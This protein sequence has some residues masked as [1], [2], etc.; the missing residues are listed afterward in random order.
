MA[1]SGVATLDFGPIGSV[2]NWA[3][4]QVTGQTGIQA[5]SMVGVWVRIEATP[6]HTES[7]LIA[8]SLRVE[9]MNIVPGVGFTIYGRCLN[10]SFYGRVKVNWAWR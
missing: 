2:R 6:E 4:V 3:T 7:E 9:A 8:E 10:G 5:S 1:G